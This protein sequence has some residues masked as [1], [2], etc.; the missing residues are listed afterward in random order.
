MAK[1]REAPTIEQIRAGEESR[2]A[3][4]KARQRSKQ[5]PVRSAEVA[6]SGFRTLRL[7][8]KD[9][10]QENLQECYRRLSDDLIVA[11]F[12]KFRY[13]EHRQRAVM[14][15]VV[16]FPELPGAL[17]VEF[18]SQLT[19]GGKGWKQGSMTVL[20]GDFAGSIEKEVQNG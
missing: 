15:G 18:L 4:R 9:R 3:E 14:Q 7:V 2:R 8:I 5:V 16:E 11:Y 19:A 13:H 20:S 6:V 10:S 1:N 12:K 17:Y